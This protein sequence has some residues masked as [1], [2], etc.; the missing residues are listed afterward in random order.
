[1]SVCPDNSFRPLTF[2]FCIAVHQ[3][4]RSRTSVKVQGNGTRKNDAKV[5]GATSG[6]GFLVLGRRRLFRPSLTALVTERECRFG[7]KYK[8][9][10]LI[11]VRK[12]SHR[13]GNLHAV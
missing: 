10:G 7:K 2:T 12:M 1:M 13:Y 5:V 9:S 4:R 11:A 3:V 6:E 8:R